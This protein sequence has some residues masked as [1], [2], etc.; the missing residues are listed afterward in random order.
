MKPLLRSIISLLLCST[1]TTS[2]ALDLKEAMA[3]AQQYDTTFQAAYSAYLAASEAS[4]QSTAAIL[5]QIDLNAH[6]QRGRIENDS[7]GTVSKSDNNNEGYSLDAHPP[8]ETQ[9]RG[10]FSTRSPRRPNLIGMS[11]VRLLEVDG[12]R[13]EDGRE[14]ICYAETVPAK[15]CQRDPDLY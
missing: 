13:R 11:I 3:L 10:V 4:T 14:N 12:N 8:M 7:G 1:A 9:V 5:P 6:F 15:S 2:S